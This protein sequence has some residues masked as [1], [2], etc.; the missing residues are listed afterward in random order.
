MIILIKKLAGLFGYRYAC[1]YNEYWH[2]PDV[3]GWRCIYCKR[4]RRFIKI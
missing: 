4:F 1:K 2:V 3:G